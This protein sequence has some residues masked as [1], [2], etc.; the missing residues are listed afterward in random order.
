MSAAVPNRVEVTDSVI[1]QKLHNEAV[2]LNLTTQ[3]YYALDDVGTRIWDLL[4]EHGDLDVVAGSLKTIYAAEE[5]TLRSD[6]DRLVGELIRLN[7]LKAS[8]A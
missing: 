2:L 1:F 4:L 3:D 5:E 7:L 8:G 6:L